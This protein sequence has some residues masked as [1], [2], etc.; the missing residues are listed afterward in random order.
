MNA[1]GADVICPVLIRVTRVY[2]WQEIPERYSFAITS[3][4]SIDDARRAG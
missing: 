4:G 1:D 3:T 2:K